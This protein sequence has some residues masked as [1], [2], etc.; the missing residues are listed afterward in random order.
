MSKVV[1]ISQMRALEKEADAKGLSYARMMANAGG[2]LADFAMTFGEK[3]QLKSAMA[4]VG[5]GN[6]GGDALVALT[7]LAE[8]GWATRAYLV[9]RRVT[10]DAL[11]KEYLKAGGEVSQFANDSDFETLEDFL[12]NSDILFDGLLGT[13]IKLP[14][15]KDAALVLSETRRIFD[16]IPYPPFL[17]A[18]DC[19]SGADCDTGECA[20]ETLAADLT[21]SMAAVKRGLLKFPAFERV[22]ILEVADIGLPEDLKA[23]KTSTLDMADEETI[24]KNLPSR[25]LA[26]HKGTFGCAFVIAGSAPYTGAALLAGKSAYRVGAG[27]VTLAIPQ[28][29]H[30]ALAGHLPEA[31]W[32]T[33]P[34]ENGFIAAEASADVMKNLNRATAVLFGPGLGEE[35]TTSAFIENLLGALDLPLVV[36]A[37]GLRHLTRVEDWKSKIKGTAILTPHPGEMSALTGLTVGTIQSNREEVALK[38]AKAWNQVV[39]LKGALTVIAE[40]SGRATI[41]PVA[42]PALAR[43]GTGDVL[44]GLIVGLRAQG[45]EAYE[46][47]VAGAMIHAQAG[48]L[49]EARIGATESV[50]AN[51]VLESVPE[52]LRRLKNRTMGGV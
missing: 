12:E 23:W 46:S 38:Y 9:G 27:L 36:D 10:G 52:L 21:I 30:A 34:H 18:V 35:S 24:L 7:I 42:T 40:P 15:R 26:A 37:D 2:A 43:A 48:L 41:I 29:L 11:V 14:L 22:G 47:A 32:L 4:V 1:S 39:V 16:E 51:D 3:N 28:P 44:A 31:T 20:A 50:L 33:L 8:E 45:V 13:G 19:P 6:N 49:A 17:V 25:P 5:S